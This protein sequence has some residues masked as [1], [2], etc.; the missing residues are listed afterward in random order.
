MHTAD[1]TAY[2]TVA[3]SYIHKILMKLTTGAIIIK[4]FTAVINEFS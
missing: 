1:S 2:F 3:I 4:L